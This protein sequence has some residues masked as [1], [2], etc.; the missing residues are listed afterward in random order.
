MTPQE[1]N[2]SIIISLWDL[3]HTNGGYYKSDKQKDFI[4]NNSHDGEYQQTIRMYGN[5]VLKSYGLDELGVTY[6][7]KEHKVKGEK[8][9]TDEWVRGDDKLNSAINK[10][11]EQKLLSKARARKFGEANDDRDKLVSEF[12]EIQCEHKRT[13][14]V[15]IGIFGEALEIV[16]EHHKSTCHNTLS[17]WDRISDET[18]EDLTTMGISRASIEEYNSLVDIIVKNS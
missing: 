15:N 8:Q 10:K 17:M 13:E 9:Y 1:L 12:I 3:I 7:R 11:Y 18:Q 16:L 4:L 14:L 2:K 6:I 5:T